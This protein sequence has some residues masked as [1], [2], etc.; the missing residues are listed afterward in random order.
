MIAWQTYKE[1]F[2]RLDFGGANAYS[3]L[4]TLITMTLAIIYI[5][6]LYRRGLVQG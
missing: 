6:L 2:A 3:Y 4:I 1:A 5:R